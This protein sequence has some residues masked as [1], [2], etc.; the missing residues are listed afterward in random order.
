LLKAQV[1]PDFL[2][3]TLNTIY[4]YANNNSPHTSTMLANL[5]DLLSYMLYDCDKPFVPL[6]KEIAIMKDYMEMAKNKI[7]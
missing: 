1:H 6:D 4:D 2:F 3:K 7:P 5:S